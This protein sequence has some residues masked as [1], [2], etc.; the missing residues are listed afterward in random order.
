MTVAK[1]RNRK[2]LIIQAGS[3]CMG[4]Y[5]YVSNLGHPKHIRRTLTVVFKKT[6]TFIL[7]RKIT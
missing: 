1:Q 7:G 3:D 5:N 6:C 4:T 2:R